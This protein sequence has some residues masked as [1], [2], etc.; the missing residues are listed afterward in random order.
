CLDSHHSAVTMTAL[1]IGIQYNDTLLCICHR[2]SA[3]HLQLTGPIWATA[4]EF[5]FLPSLFCV[6]L[7]LDF[8]RKRLTFNQ[9][10][11]F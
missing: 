7:L 6:A 8:S 3:K 5:L 2:T 4:P 1:L 9:V 10:P 11:G